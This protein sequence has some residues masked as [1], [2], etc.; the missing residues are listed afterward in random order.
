[1]QWWDNIW[2]NEGFATWME[3]K[4][5]EKWKPEWKISEVVAEELQYTLDLDAQRTTRTIRAKAETPDEINEM[6]DGITYG[7]AGAVL[8]MVENYVGEETFR[9]GVHDYLAAHLYANAT[10]EDFW[11]AQTKTSHKPVDQIMNSLV[12]QPGVPILNFDQPQSGSVGVNQQRFFLSSKSKA[13]T[14]Q[15]W[16]I[17][18]CLKAASGAP[19]CEVLNKAQEKI[20][21]PPASFFYP[22]AGGKGYYR[23]DYP[24]DVY[25]KLVSNVAGLTPEERISLLGDQWVKVR[26]DKAKAGSFLNLVSAVK[27]DTSSTVADSVAGSIEAIDTQIASDSDR[28]Q[29]AVWV[30][31][32]FADP[33]NRLGPP[34]ATDT[35]DKSELRAVLFYMMGAMGKDPQVIADARKISAQYLEEPSSVDAT[36]ARIAV[37][38][39][40]M[41]GDEAFFNK[42]QQVSATSSNPE[43]ASGALYALGVFQDPALEKRALDYAVSGKVKNQDSTY[44]ISEMLGNRETRTIAWQYVQQNWD[45]VKAQFTTSSGSGLVRAT[46]SFCTVAERDQM[47]SFFATHKVPASERALRRA[48][49]RINDCIDLH[50]SQQPNLKAWLQGQ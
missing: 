10:A 31:K 20:S 26:A 29:L 49:D 13:P 46:G 39:A 2:L 19:S 22:N 45:K 7:K 27:D 9:Q 47:T 14:P 25:Q 12:S 33:L 23:T 8:L 28:P 43:V 16:T 21:V 32:T 24:E 48:T 17:P 50:A 40:A 35:P 5:L 15:V 37:E 3:N 42:L 34:S 6:F 1:M 4:P 18:A 41:H 11:S 30:R 44:L 36:L 38:I